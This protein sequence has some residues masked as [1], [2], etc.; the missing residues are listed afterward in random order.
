MIRAAVLALL[1]GVLAAGEA[2]PDGWRADLRPRDDAWKAVPQRFVFNN[3]SEPQSLDPALMTGVLESRL[4]MALFEGLAMRDPRTLEPRPAAA[5]RWESDAAGLV[6]TFHLRP[7][8]RWSDGQPVIAQD[9]VLSWRRALDPATGSEYAGMLY[10]IR[11]AEAYH[12]GQGPAD[13]VAV[14]AVDQLTLRVELHGPCPWFLDLVTFHTLY[15]VRTD[16]VAAHGAAWT[17]TALVGNGPFTLAAWEPRS[18]IVLERSATYWD[19]ERVP[20]ERITARPVDDLEAAWS[21]FQAGELHWTPAIPAARIDDIKRHPDFIATPYFGTYYFRFN[22][23]RPPFDDARIRR[24]FV[25][26]TDRERVTR[27]ITRSGEVPAPW[28]VPR[29]PQARGPGLAFDVEA[30]RAELAA[31]GYAAPGKPGRPLPPVVLLYNT[32]EN[33]KAIAEHLAQQWQEHLGA[34]IRL[35][36]AEWKVYLDRMKNLDYGLARSAWIGDYLDSNTFLELGRTGDGNNRTG[37]SDP[38]YDRLLAASQIETDPERRRTMLDRLERILVEEQCP[39][40]PVYTYVNK[41]L[42]REE[43]HGLHQNLL[44]HHPWQ[45]IWL[46]P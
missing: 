9:F 15:P 18:S 2:D 31:A 16:V 19:R 12:R 35:E 22:C 44:D 32:S 1:A 30:A 43:V 20:L 42:V 37:W 6:W 21:L 36:N 28:F 24:A 5:R 25:R 40:L 38:E 39:V 10:P 13:A 14:R 11:G 26:G 27:F 8:G 41:A 46:E 17:R 33:H 34:E 7:E 45:F 29:G 4:A 3:E 23:T